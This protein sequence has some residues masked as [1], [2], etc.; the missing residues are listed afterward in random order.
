M[1]EAGAIGHCQVELGALA[2]EGAIERHDWD[3]A[4]QQCRRLAHYTRDEP[5]PLSDFII[6]RAR[7]LAAR[8]RSHDNAAEIAA[9]VA[10]ARATGLGLY[11]TGLRPD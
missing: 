1:L 4:E 3:E 7:A 11:L 5:L 9:L 10:E 2:I 8:A 6:R